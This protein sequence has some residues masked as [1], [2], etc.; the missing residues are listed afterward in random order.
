MNDFI[1]ATFL[2]LREIRTALNELNGS[3]LFE[4]RFIGEGGDASCG[5]DLKAEEILVTYLSS[6]GSICSEE[7]GWISPKTDCV[8]VLDPVDG[9]DNFSSSFP[10]YGVSVAREINGETTDAVVC[11]LANGDVFVRTSDDYYRCPLD[12][13][14]LKSPINST[15]NSKIGLF[16]KSQEHPKLIEMLMEKKLKFRSPGAVALSLAYA[17][18]V[19]YVLFLG[20]MRQFDIQAGLYLNKHLYKFNDDRYLLVSKSKEVFDE[21]QSIV[22]KGYF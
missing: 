19:N 13:L 16:E 15:D 9:S 20:T 14:S 22:E 4:A 11:N 5:Y 7:S 6:F 8:I 3:V 17:P 21:V 18:Y 10:Y 1:S 12:D 2:A